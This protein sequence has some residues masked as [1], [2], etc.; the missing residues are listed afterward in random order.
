VIGYGP[1][2]RT[3]VQQLQDNGI[4][5]IVIELNVEVVRALR[6]SG[7]DAIYGDAT[8][9]DTIEAAG[10]ASA[11]HVILSSAGMSNGAEVIRMVRAINPQ[12]R[13]LA[14]T[15]Y[16]REVPELRLAGATRVYSGEG[17]IALAF[18]EDILNTLGATPEQIDRERAR[19]HADLAA[20]H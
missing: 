9:I 17:E 1:T 16:L 15:S 14:R 4:V 3:V 20:L 5:P 8:R 13:V 2:G 19:V 12:I 18:V 10:A 11:A 6:S 7:V